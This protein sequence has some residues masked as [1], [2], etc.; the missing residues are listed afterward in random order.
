MKGNNIE[1]T[2]ISS[3]T[4]SDFYDKNKGVLLVGEGIYA[5]YFDY[6]KEYYP[7]MTVEKYRND[8]GLTF[9]TDP[10]VP[11][12]E[13]V[14]AS[15]PA[16]DIESAYGFTG[17]F[18]ISGK[19]VIKNGVLSEFLS[20]GSRRV[21]LTGSIII[22]EY[23]KY[24]FSAAGADMEI[25][26]DDKPHYGEKLSKGIHKIKIVL[27]GMRQAVKLN[28]K[29]LDKNES[30]PVSAILRKDALY[31]VNVT[32]NF[33]FLDDTLKTMEPV[34][35]SR[36]Y[37]FKPRMKVKNDDQFNITFGGYYK[38]ETK[39]SYEFDFETSKEF[40]NSVK[41][42][43]R[44]MMEFSGDN[45]REKLSELNPGWHKIEITS[46]SRLIQSPGGIYFRLKVKKPG[47]SGFTVVKY[48]ELRPY[49]EN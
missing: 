27:S 33:N 9:W 24:Q 15:I 4:P 34:I 29:Y 19:Q 16:K 25:Y 6:L 38:A 11:E 46:L 2:D 41:L 47:E 8:S 22:P 20:E 13:F 35:N 5:D 31:G 18:N 30:I 49:P 40:C 36:M 12:Y 32:Y 10:F 28:W 42:N 23:A 48:N 21:V 14:T 39:G 43:G 3:L 1:M 7:N 37:W 17:K 26:I 44:Q 45:Y